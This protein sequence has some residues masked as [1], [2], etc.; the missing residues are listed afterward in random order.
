MND[1]AAFIRFYHREAK[2]VIG[3]YFITRNQLRFKPEYKRFAENILEQL[4]SSDTSGAE[5]L[6]VGL[7]V[8]RTDYVQFSKVYLNK[9]VVGKTYFLEAIEYFQ[10]EYPD[11]KVYFVAVSDDLPWVGTPH[12]VL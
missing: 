5:P 7:H 11:N 1:N 6:F 4:S 8:R 10:E 2:S 3:K 12:T 9:N